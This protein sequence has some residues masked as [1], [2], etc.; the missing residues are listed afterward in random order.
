[1]ASSPALFYLG[2]APAFAPKMPSPMIRLLILLCLSS[3]TLTAQRM[4]PANT[5]PAVLEDIYKGIRDKHPFA[6]THE[7]MASLEKARTLVQSRLEEAVQGQD[8]LSYPAFFRL[9]A[10]I[11]QATECGHLVLEPHL[12]SLEMLAVRENRFSLR[13]ILLEDDSFVLLKGLE[14]TTYSLAP[15]TQ[16]IA[17]DGRPVG[18]LLGD[19]AF[20]S[21]VNDRKNDRAA[22]AKVERNCTYY[23]QWYYG[24]KKSLTISTVGPDGEV[25]VSTILP[26][27]K[28]Y[29]DPKVT[30][31]D[32]N[33]TLSFRFSPDGET[34]I[35][36]IKKFSSW[37]FNNGNYYK[38]IRNVFETMRTTNTQQL[39]IDIRDNT[40]GSS[41]R[42]NGLYAYLANQKFCF[43]SD[44]LITG[45]ARAEAGEDAKTTRRRATGVVSKKERKIKRSLS[46]QLKPRKEEQ[47]FNGRVVVLINEVSFS[48]SGIFARYV[49]GSGRGQLVGATAGAS[50][51]ITYGASGKRKPFYVGSNEEFELKINTIGL[52]PEFP[53]AGNVTPDHIVFPTAAGLT[54]GRD[55]QLEKALEVVAEQ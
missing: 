5:A 50:A 53:L 31:T 32:I 15:G 8:S 54:A 28:K 14:T 45:P 4:L 13:T 11:Q 1:M 49:Q 51:G 47:R 24:V 37:K 46:R 52:V 2:L 23:Y 7:G 34:G 30:V 42:I 39:I 40:G 21:G 20:F 17:I 16:L 22:L 33:K 12:D 41:A 44:V 38:Y 48:A 55:E 10:P 3:A 36:G 18:K 25:K 26:K 9:V 43:A 29:V 6:A 27:H 35:L 19:M